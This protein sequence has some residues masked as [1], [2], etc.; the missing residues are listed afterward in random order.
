MR[1]SA[2]GRVWAPA[3]TPPPARYSAAEAPFYALLTYFATMSFNALPV[4]NNPCIMKTI[5]SA[6]G[7]SLLILTSCGGQKKVE[8]D[9]IQDNIDNAVAQNTI[10]TRLPAEK[11]LQRRLP[12]VER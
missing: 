10:Q 9:F 8:V 2:R 4:T 7:V 3:P 1:A 11:V 12:Q 6:L 5:L